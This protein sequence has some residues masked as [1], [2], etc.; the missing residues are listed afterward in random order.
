MVV[1]ESVEGEKRA[2]VK[3]ASVAVR[4]VVS[5][6]PATRTQTV[7]VGHGAAKDEGEGTT[8]EGRPQE[9]RKKDHRRRQS[10]VERMSRDR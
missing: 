1:N 9:K 2:D 10:S 5:K 3:T 6:A 4:K 8:E 7:L